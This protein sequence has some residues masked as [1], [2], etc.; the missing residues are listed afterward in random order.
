MYKEI[1]NGKK[2]PLS[3]QNFIKCVLSLFF[4]IKKFKEFKNDEVFDIKFKKP[5]FTKKIN[6]KNQELL[7]RDG[8]KKFLL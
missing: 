7:F 4:D 2:K 1:S 6:E 5:I 3:F 8:L